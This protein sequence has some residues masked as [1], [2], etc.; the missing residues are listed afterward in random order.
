MNQ[1]KELI[2]IDEVR[3]CL[4]YCPVSGVLTWKKKVAQRTRVGG[5]AGQLNKVSGYWQCSFKSR[6]HQAHRLAFFW[7][8]AAW[9]IGHIDHKNG[10]RADNRWENLRDVTRVENS[11]NQRRSHFDN[12]SCGLLGV[13]WNKRDKRWSAAVW[14]GGKRKHIG[15]FFTPEQAHSAYLVAKRVLHSGCTI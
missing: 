3:E 10:D 7:M 14:V 13:T 8:T 1:D 2:S 12:K 11:Q 9:P 6:S 4:S 5:I 15:N